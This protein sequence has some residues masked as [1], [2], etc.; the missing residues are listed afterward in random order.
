MTPERWQRISDILE[1]ALERAPE[2]RR[3]WLAA[4]CADDDEVRR[5]A[6]SLLDRHSESMLLDRPVAEVAARLLQDAPLAAGTQLGP[7]RIEQPLGAGGMGVVYRARD[8]K[9]DR[10]VA[11]KT[12]PPVFAAD[13]ERLARFTREARLLATLN[14]PNI[15]AI[16]GLEESTGQVALVL[17]LVDGPTLADRIAQG[18]IPIDEALAIARQVVDALQGAHALGIVHRDLKPANIKV[19]EDGTVKVLDFGLAKIADASADGRPVEQRPSQ[20]PTITTPAMTAA[21]IILGTAAYM[22][23]EQAK[24]KPAD[25]RSDIWAFGCVL[26]EMLTS[27]RAF[28]GEDVA[29]TLA[30]VIK[31]TPDWS[32]PPARLS[33]SIDTL[34]RRCLE[35][36]R[37]RRIADVSTIAFLL[38][39]PEF[40]T[41]APDSSPQRQPLWRRLIAPLAAALVAAGLVGVGVWSAMR[42]AAP[43]VTRFALST[44][45]ANALVV[46]AQSRD[47][48][49]TPDGTQVVYKGGSENYGSQLFVRGIGQLEP[50]PVTPPGGPKA[51]FPSPDGQW[52]GFFQPG[53]PVTLRKVAITGGPAVEL[54][55]IDGPSRGATWGADDTIIFATAALSTGLQRVASAGGEPNVL[56]RPDRERGESDHL[57]PQLLPGG[58]AV[59]FTVTATTGGMDAAQVAVL[60]LTTGTWSSLVRGGSQAVYVSSGHLVYVAAGALWAVPF[61][62][63]RLELRGVASPVLSPLVILPNGTAEFD[64]ARDG[65]LVYVS[66]GPTTSLRRLAWVD[67]NGREQVIAATPPRHYGAV[68]LSPDG[69]RVALEIWDQGNDIWTL[70]LARDTLTRVTTDPGLDLSPVWMP[71]GRRLL[72]TSQAGGALGSIFSRAADGTGAVERLT[73]STHVERA[74]HVLADGAGALFASGSGIMMLRLADRRVSSI[75]QVPQ[76]LAQ[77]GVV[78]P[79]GRWLAHDGSDGGPIQ[80]FVRPFPNAT[81][82]R[83]QIS[84]IGGSHPRWSRNGRELFYMAPDGALMSVLVDPG[85]TW[86]A[87]TPTRVSQG[88]YVRATGISGTRTYDISPDGQRFLVLKPVEGTQTAPPQ[89]VVVQNWHEEL[90]R[91]VPTGR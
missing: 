80:V 41:A 59:L 86:A 79:D 83:T 61:D 82:G 20:S 34:L 10:A 51:P 31:G 55:G 54:C 50:T 19:R 32:K 9:L 44:T 14:H 47:L 21:G 13:A 27:R 45:A 5:E 23:P 69:T 26:Y 43:R 63:T 53:G 7:Y 2:E 11:I 70:D 39:E 30:E 16:Y 33:R 81:E 72:F 52:I 89:V 8:T 42:P 29:E 62:L 40:G 68:S 77:N 22:S 24:G 87:K 6:E 49:I 1:A 15:G 35:K 84:A 60:D 28:D 78:S 3:A 85:P 58:R 73:E 56:T 18:P 66:G 71:D 48:T 37:K 12:L 67:R 25:K 64:I 17:E 4:A 38:D 57:Y 46:D 36:D 88:P 74:T 76:Q 75:L 90:K 65:T 91:L